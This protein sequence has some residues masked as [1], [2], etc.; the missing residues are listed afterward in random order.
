MSGVDGLLCFA[1]YATNLAFNRLYARLLSELGLTYPQYLVMMALWA[2][3]D[4]TVGGIGDALFLESNTLTPLL[5]RLEAS[6]LVERRRDPAD[7]RV[8]RVRL[9]PHGDALRE[10]AQALRGCVVEAAGLP[11]GE[12]SELLLRLRALNENLQRAAADPPPPI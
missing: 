4:R 7:E 8:V 5:K 12:L 3:D 10:R 1:T 2:E 6:G 9:T 11:E